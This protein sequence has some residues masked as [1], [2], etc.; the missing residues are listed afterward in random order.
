MINTILFLAVSISIILIL[1]WLIYRK[2]IRNR[3][4]ILINIFLSIFVFLIVSCFSLKYLDVLTK[5]NE[6]ISVPNL[7]GIQIDSAKVILKGNGLNCMIRDSVYSDD[8][9]MGMVI[10]QDPKPH[11]ETFPS[12]VKPSRTIY[13]TIVKRIEE[14]KQIPDLL[15]NVTSKDIGKARLEMLGFKVDFLLKE[16]KDK[17]RVLEIL[18]GQ[19]VV[20]FGDSVL[21]GTALTLVYGSGEKGKPIELP[22]LKGKSIDYAAQY[23][24]EIGLEIEISYDSVFNESDSN[25]AVIYSQ[26]PNPENLE[27]PIIFQG[28]IIHVYANLKTSLDSTNFNMNLDSNLDSINNNASNE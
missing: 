27:N 9:Q 28:S 1:F 7:L 12:Y 23:L 10:R 24:N 20:S 2:K 25:N 8:Y 22:N 26:Y 13:L 5:H 11:A 4:K 14:Y 3:Y 18:Q 15:S 21:K 17:D 19:D 16:H 6:T